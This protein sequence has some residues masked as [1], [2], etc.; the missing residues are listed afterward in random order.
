MTRK[1]LV[2][3]LKNHPESPETGPKILY[4][5]EQVGMDRYE[6]KKAIFGREAEFL[7]EILTDPHLDPELLTQAVICGFKFSEKL[8]QL[9]KGVEAK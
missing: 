8:I 9:V 1:R 4:V 3:E 6:I 7:Y 2:L 5:K